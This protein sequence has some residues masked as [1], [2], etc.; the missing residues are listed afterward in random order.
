[1]LKASKSM[2]AEKVANIHMVVTRSKLGEI[3]LDVFQTF[4]K[5]TIP[6]K[7][8]GFLVL[9]VEDE[10]FELFLPNISAGFE[11]IGAMEVDIHYIGELLI[12]GHNLKFLRNMFLI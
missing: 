8:D 9:L 4:I 3:V 5:N 11:Q 2:T 7:I 1:M 6:K 12:F 10:T